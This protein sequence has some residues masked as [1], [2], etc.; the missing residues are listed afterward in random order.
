MGITNL[1]F[2]IDP[3]ACVGRKPSGGFTNLHFPQA[4]ATRKEAMSQHIVEVEDKKFVFGWDQPLQSFYLQVHDLTRPEDDEENPRIIAWY[5]ATK[6]TTMYE[7]DD[8]A[9]KARRHGLI[10]SHGMRVKLYGEKDDGI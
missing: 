4:K 1:H 10:I 7:I 3:E 8:L 6:D 2:L 9:D 5:G